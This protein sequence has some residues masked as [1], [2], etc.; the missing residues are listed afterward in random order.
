MFETSLLCAGKWQPAATGQTFDRIGPLSSSVS[1]RCAAASINDVQAVLAAASDA[2]QEW[3]A[4]GPGVRRQLLL[5]AADIL[6]GYA[7]EFV[8]R[9]YAE[10]GATEAWARFN[11]K[12][13]AG[14]FREAGAM[15]TRIAG[16]II[17]SD[18]PG[19]LAMAV[20][21][22]AGVSLGIAPWNAPVILAA[23]AISMPLACGNA[24]I[25]K[26]SEN[27]PATHELVCRALVEAGLPDGVISF[28]TNAP[29]DAGEI[30]GTII[31]HPSVARI[32]FTGSTEVGR[33]IALRAAHALKP[34]LLELGGKAPF[35]VLEDA[36][37]DAAVAAAAFGTF[38][39]QGQI[40]MSTERIIV[41][42]KIADAFT[43]KLAKKVSSLRAGD[44]RKEKGIQLGPL[45]NKD[46]SQR[47]AKMIEDACAKGAHLI[48]GGASN[49]AIMQPT[50]IDGVDPTMR[51]YKEETFGPIAG[52]IR[53][54]SDEEAI[55]IANDT[56]YG[57]TGAVFSRDVNRAMAVAEKV[58]SGMCHINGPTVHD[59]AQ[60]PF[61]GVK[62][63]G[64][65]RF[66]G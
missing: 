22:P 6:E 57:L 35:I 41:D 12:L 60:M 20:R 27:C 2:Q 25:L 19:S 24:S 33:K 10:L 44:P 46:A 23:R 4:T 14:M 54:K 63:S 15:T 3:G 30:V 47:I 7:D 1:S 16:E 36:D 65:G 53:V 11:A 28:L 26:G 45:A 62:E 49:S 43:E 18:M 32:N 66:G 55:S 31:D 59:E 13:G 29:E 9:M 58:E 34:A 64:Y 8:D 50:L 48:T 56:E 51:I 17:P 38:M 42:E 52:I 5:K 21:Q 61:G 40:C 39:N 37:L